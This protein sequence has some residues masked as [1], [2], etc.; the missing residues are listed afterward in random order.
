MVGKKKEGPGRR[1]GRVEKN[2]R[3]SEKKGSKCEQMRD[4][5]RLEN[6]YQRGK[7]GSEK[8]KGRKEENQDS[9]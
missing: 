4:E 3:V 6:I 5:R 9:A 1:W 8:E 2:K 7:C